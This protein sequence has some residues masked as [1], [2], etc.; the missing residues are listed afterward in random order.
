MSERPDGMQIS[1]NELRALTEDLKQMHD[2]TFPALEKTLGG[3]RNGVSSVAGKSTNRRFFMLGGAT[4]IGGSALA[5]CSSK[6]SDNNAGAN[7]SSSD[8][9]YTGDLKVVA[10]AAALE[11]LAVAA[12]GMALTEAGKGTYGKVPAAVGEFITVAKKQHADHAKGWN[13]VL[14]GA[15]KPAVTTPALSITDGAV[16][17]LMAAKTI[18]AVAE[19]A[20][21]LENSAA[22]T[23]VFATANVTDPGGIAVAGTIAPVEAQHA[24]VL[25]FILGKYPVPDT[26]IGT[27]MAVQPSMLTI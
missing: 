27:S 10:L 20:L 5:A 9:P 17:S 26:F 11:N 15:G 6:K 14:T 1:E 8:S 7:P 3:F 12:Y 19:I 13:A 21:G 23:Y 16:K 25:S 4:I 24:M 22:Q 18:P 2:D